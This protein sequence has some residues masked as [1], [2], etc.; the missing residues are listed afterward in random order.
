MAEHAVPEEKNK[1]DEFRNSG[2]RV[3]DALADHLAS[4]EDRSLFPQVTPSYV[5]DLFDEPMPE[6]GSPPDEVLKAIEEKL[7]PNC[8]QVTHPGYMG[9]ITPTPLPVGALGDFIAS[10]INQNVGTYSL[11]PAAVAIERRTVRWLLDLVGYDQAAGGNLTSGGTMA[12]FIGLKLARDFISGNK[13]QHEGVRDRWAVYMSDQRQVSLDKAVDAIGVGREAMKLVPTNER[14]EIDID[15]LEKAI[16]RDKAEGLKPLCIVAMAGTTN[17]GS[18]DD[19]VALR[20]IANR[21]GMWLHADAAYGGGMILSHNPGPACLKGLE[22]ADSITM[23]PHKWF[24]APVDAGAILVRDGAQLWES[25][26]MVPAYLKDEHDTEGERFQYFAHS[27][28][29]SR[30][31]R[32]LKVWM[33]FKRYGTKQIG[34]WIDENIAQARHLHGLVEASDDFHSACEPVMSAVCLRY[35]PPSLADADEEVIGRLHHE[36]ALRIEQGGKFW[37]GTTLMKGQWWFRINPVNFRTTISHMDELYE[38]LQRECAEV[39]A[40]LGVK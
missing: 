2:H 13:A 5:N 35:Q 21:E 9:L 31:F 4:I 10:T 14:Y 16:A 11:G 24:F 37:F 30:R 17:T 7:L 26:G 38:T 39:E 28:E 18:V 29:Q 6:E 1:I 34:H 8:T 19:L 3:V 27:F 25:F 33:I 36:V 22:L 32:G 23:D 40:A 20:T 15:E 12:N